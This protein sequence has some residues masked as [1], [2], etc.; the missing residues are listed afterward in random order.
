MREKGKQGSKVERRQVRGRLGRKDG[1]KEGG[2]GGEEKQVQELEAV[3]VAT[4]DL[5]VAGPTRVL[6]R[7]CGRRATPP[8]P[9]LQHP[10][11]PHR[12]PPSASRLRCA[13]ERKVTDV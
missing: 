7:A 9:H 2:R 5:L 1:G 6:Q 12:R 4:Q 11:Y 8:L 3:G 10:F 13:H